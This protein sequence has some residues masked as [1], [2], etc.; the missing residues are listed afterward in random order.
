MLQLLDTDINYLKSLI[1]A[2]IDICSSN[3][4]AIY[5]D[6]II[7]YERVLLIGSQ[8]IKGFGN[9]LFKSDFFE[10]D[11]GVVFYDYTIEKSV[12]ASKYNNA[13]LYLETS[14]VIEIQI[15]GRPF[16]VKEFEEYPNIYEKYQGVTKTD[17]IFLFKCKAGEQIMLVFHPY[18]PQIQVL[19]NPKAIDSFWNEY[20]KE[21]ES[22][23]SYLSTLTISD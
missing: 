18:F 6:Y 7:S 2:G 19:F 15:F 8:K 5:N 14:P 21:Y 12:D 20:K 3:R 16:N 13:E 4:L 23:Y 17:D 22:H 9:I 11:N 10:N 1:G